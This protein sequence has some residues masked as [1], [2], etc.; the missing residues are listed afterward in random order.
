MRH[1]D[2]RFEWTREQFQEWCSTMNTH[3]QY[4][5]SFTGIGDR[6][7][8]YGQPTQMCIFRKKRRLFYE[9]YHTKHWDCSANWSIQ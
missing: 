8:L 6:H 5:L 1:N 7:E 9:H 2:H 3:E 4:E